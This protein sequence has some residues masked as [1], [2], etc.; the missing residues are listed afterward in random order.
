MK[1]GVAAVEVVA[2]LL[3]AV[4]SK[5]AI[6]AR[7]VLDVYDLLPDTVDRARA[8]TILDKKAREDIRL[9]PM[10]QALLSYLQWAAPDPERTACEARAEALIADIDAKGRV[11]PPESAAGLFDALLAQAEQQFLY[12]DFHGVLESVAQ[13]RTALPCLDRVVAKAQLRSLFLHEAVAYLHLGDPRAEQIFVQMLVVDPRVYLEPEHPPRVRKAF[14]EAAEQFMALE[15]RPLD[16]G[17]LP[18]KV[19]V[20]GLPADNVNEV[21]PGRH[22]VQIEGPEGRIRSVLLEVPG[23]TGPVRLAPL[24]DVGLPDTA[25]VLDAL[26]A[27]LRAGRLDQTQKRG[28]D[29]YLATTGDTRIFFA[30]LHDGLAVEIY[31][32]HAGLVDPTS[33]AYGRFFRSAPPWRGLAP[34]QLVSSRHAGLGVLSSL[35]V[36]VGGALA[37]PSAWG[38]F[39]ELNFY[40]RVGT[41]WYPGLFGQLA[42]QSL[43][44]GVGY[45]Q[46]RF[47]AVLAAKLPIG[48]HLA[49]LPAIGYGAGKG[50]PVDG[51]CTLGTVNDQEV[52]SCTP[53]SLSSADNQDE[54]EAILSSRSHGPLARLE[55]LVAGRT[56]THAWSIGLGLQGSFERLAVQDGSVSVNDQVWPYTVSLASG[57]GW[58]TVV[59]AVVSCG[60]EF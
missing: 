27:G 24:V 44:D 46:A 12:V 51:T 39:L 25:T 49:F 42:Y 47:G 10:D 58:V 1:R 41:L 5:P 7:D 19:Y 6:A 53:G 11:S 26:V 56:E 15:P 13:A 50:P 30:L 21:R 18:G 40:K 36:G 55:L 37:G 4:C 14:L 17:G 29:Q 33:D 9:V 57:A 23:G 8:S 20:D 3:L 45:L 54:L 52:M 38:G 2:G 60:L 31:E 34:T 48:A 59:N 43:D 22:L 35:R 32:A 28:L 16:A